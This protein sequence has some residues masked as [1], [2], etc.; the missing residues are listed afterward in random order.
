MAARISVARVARQ[1]TSSAAARR[2][3]AFVCQRWQQQQ[4]RPS[5]RLFSVS[6]ALKEKKY[7][8]DHEWIEMSA[9]G[10]TCTLGISEYAAKALGDVVY[11]ELPQV[12]MD[13]SEGDAIGAVESVKSA[14]DI[15][16]PISGTVVEVNTAL[17]SK[18][19]DV[20]KDPEGEA[21]IAK[22][23]V[24]AEPSMKT[25]SKEEYAAFTEE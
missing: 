21:W 4:A 15:L 5:Q 16:T 12:E 1:F 9:D 2:P 18:P 22:I 11:I 20:N 8:E 6:A 17:E 23:T 14:S 25:M 3:S 24:S 10:K 13:V 7:T 19:G